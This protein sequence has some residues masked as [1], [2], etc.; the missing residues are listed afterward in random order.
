MSPRSRDGSQIRNYTL[1]PLREAL[2]DLR[3]GPPEDFGENL[4]GSLPRGKMLQGRDE[5]QTNAMAKHR[6]LDALESESRQTFVAIR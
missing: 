3:R 2:G 6:G 4:R 1:P 5:R